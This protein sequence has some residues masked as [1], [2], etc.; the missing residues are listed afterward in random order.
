MGETHDPLSLNFYTYCANSPV[1]YIDS[2]GNFF[3][4]VTAA[5]GAVAGAVVGG[6]IAA[7]NGKNVWAGIGIGAAAGGLIGLTGGAATAFL[8]AGSVTASTGA[9]LTGMGVIGATSGGTVLWSGGKTVMNYAQKFASQNGMVTLEQTIRGR[10]LELI[11]KVT[12][13][14]IG[15]EK[16][17]NLLKPLW[18]KA[19]TQ[20]VQSADGTVH[21]FL[22]SSGISDTSIF[23]TI[24]YN[25][26]KE[27]G[28]EIVFHLVNTA[29]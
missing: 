27:T 6:I 11:N 10:T 12:T 13:K 20:F 16:A 26:L 5:I 14:L 3:M 22:N 1:V 28:Q 15:S 23:M 19:S 7:K 4:F 8:A 29:K 2:G 9:V 17:Y 18:E 25:I 21:A 24:E